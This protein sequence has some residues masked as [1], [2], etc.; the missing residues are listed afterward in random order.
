MAESRDPAQLRTTESAIDNSS[1]VLQPPKIVVLADLNDDP[2]ESDGGE[3][4]PSS[5]PDLARFSLLQPSLFFLH[6]SAKFVT[7]FHLF[8]VR[9]LRNSGEQKF[10]YE[11]FFTKDCFFF[12]FSC[13]I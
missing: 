3:S 10:D 13:R 4:L 12:G 1:K 6:K 7:I 8:S 11:L 9:S 2:P 5:A